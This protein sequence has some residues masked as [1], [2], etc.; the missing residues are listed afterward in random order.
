[1]GGVMM[2]AKKQTKR[3]KDVQ[4][5]RMEDGAS[6]PWTSWSENIIRKEWVCN[7]FSIVTLINFVG[8]TAVKLK[9][10]TDD[11]TQFWVCPNCGGNTQM[12][13]NRQ[14]CPSCKFYLSI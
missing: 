14:Y 10:I 9:T 3:R 13:D 7:F 12:K 11:E 1:M 2:G 5:I 8:A 6:M 4:D